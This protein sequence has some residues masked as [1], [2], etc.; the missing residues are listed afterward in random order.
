MEFRFSTLCCI[1]VIWLCSAC[2]KP[3]GYGG[4]NSIEGFLFTRYYND[5]YSLLISE[6]PAIDE[7][8]FILFGDEKAIGDRTVTSNS[9]AFA[10]D[11]LRQ[12]L[13]TL[14]YGSDD[15]TGLYA[16]G[17]VETVEVDLTDSKSW[18]GDTLFRIETLDFDDGEAAIS[19]TIRLVN[20]RNETEPPF[21]VVKDTSFAQEHEV[22]LVYGNHTFYDERIRTD[23]KGYFRF[24]NLI[25][26]SYT[27]FTYSEDLEGGTGDIPVIL[28]AEITELGQ[29]ID[30]GEFLIYQR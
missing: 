22:Y 20:F 11:F 4:T 19:G 17:H 18:P 26:G 29:E 14:Y 8:V 3:A 13:Y 2:E 25:P 21:L 7:E 24:S 30:L 15:S 16:E 12:G 6:A 27:L 1:G 23:Y 10:F 28:T 9:G 5:D